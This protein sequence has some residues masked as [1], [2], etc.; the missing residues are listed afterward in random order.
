MLG[1]KITVMPKHE[2][3]PHKHEYEQLVYILA[4]RIRFHVGDE[5]LVLGPG[6]CCKFR[7]T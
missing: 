3:K 1:P 7:R 2:P 6:G 4:G 5:S